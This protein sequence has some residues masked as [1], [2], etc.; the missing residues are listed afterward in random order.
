MGGGGTVK[1]TNS[2]ARGW[3]AQGLDLFYSSPKVTGASEDYG[4]QRETMGGTQPQRDEYRQEG[5]EEAS[6]CS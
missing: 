2:W 3:E 6:Q 1:G 5:K 4:C